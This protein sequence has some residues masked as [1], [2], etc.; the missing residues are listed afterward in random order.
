MDTV[1]SYFWGRTAFLNPSLSPFPRVMFHYKTEVTTIYTAWTLTQDT[2]DFIRSIST[3][4][5]PYSTGITLRSLRFILTRGIDAARGKPQPP[6]IPDGGRTHVG[7][8]NPRTKSRCAT[9]FLDQLSLLTR[10]GSI[11]ASGAL[12]RPSAFGFFNWWFHHGVDG[13]VCS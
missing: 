1:N 7:R 4:N 10:V 8:T 5:Q 12:S 6:P 3:H 13:R 11:P 9:L 2:C